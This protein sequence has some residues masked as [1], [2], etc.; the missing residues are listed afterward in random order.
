MAETGIGICNRRSNDTNLVDLTVK[1]YSAFGNR[2][3]FSVNSFLCLV[4][5]V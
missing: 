4:K 3:R 5:D 2:C 1:K